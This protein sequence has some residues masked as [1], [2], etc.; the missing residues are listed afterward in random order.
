MELRKLNG[1]DVFKMSKIL[2]KMDLKIEATR[3]DYKGEIIPKTQVEVGIELFKGLLENLHMAQNEVNDFLGDLI[4]CSGDEF[5]KK[6]LDEILEV[7][8][9]FQEMIK[10]TSFFT[11]VSKLMK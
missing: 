5:G 4:N 1:N 6:D 11:T 3:I 10:G 9:K 8:T 2:K 7:M